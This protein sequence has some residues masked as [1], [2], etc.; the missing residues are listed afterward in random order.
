MRHK[1]RWLLALSLTTTTLPALPSS[2]R[3]EPAL[4]HQGKDLDPL[5]YSLGRHK[6]SKKCCLF[7]VAV[8]R[9]VV[10]VVVVVVVTTA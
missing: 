2:G 9:Q 4:L 10:V 3:S 1:P 7:L 6:P 5:F 8:V